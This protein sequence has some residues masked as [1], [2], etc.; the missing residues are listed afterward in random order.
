MIGETVGVGP[1][2]NAATGSQDPARLSACSDLHAAENGTAQATI[3]SRG[4]APKVAA[5]PS[6]DAV[7]EVE[8][9]LLDEIYH[10]L[11]LIASYTTSALE[12][13]KRGDREELRLRLRGQL[14]DCFRHAVELHNLLP[15]TGPKGG[16]S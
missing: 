10:D 4:V 6:P 7:A 9:F 1:R 13:A 3:A 5:A 11:W 2:G 14:R 15:P 8:E 12:A 16:R